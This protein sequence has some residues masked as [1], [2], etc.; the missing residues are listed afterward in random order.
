MEVLLVFSK[1]NIYKMGKVRDHE[2]DTEKG[3][4]HVEKLKADLDMLYK[5][6]RVK[7]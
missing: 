5:N 1:I 3:K 2:R 4:E 6:Q 7:A